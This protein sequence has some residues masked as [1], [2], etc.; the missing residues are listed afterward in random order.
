MDICAYSPERPVSNEEQRGTLAPAPRANWVDGSASLSD[1]RQLRRPAGQNAPTTL[2][3]SCLSADAVVVVADRRLTR[4]DT[5]APLD[6]DACKVILLGGQAAIPHGHPKQIDLWIVD[7]LTPPPSQL[8]EVIDRLGRA[9][10]EAFTPIASRQAARHAFMISGWEVAG[11]RA[12]PFHTQLSNALDAFGRW[13]PAAAPEFA[14][15]TWRLGG[16]AIALKAIGHPLDPQRGRL[17][18]RRLQDVR[19]RHPSRIASLLASAVREEARTTNTVGEGL[20]VTILPRPTGT[21]TRVIRL[22][23][24]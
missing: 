15:R 11:E 22:S 8:Q 10:V 16:D 18:R 24:L 2:V 21:G 9:S 7:V 17:L 14:M 5:G 20:L 4:L 1:A 13:R 23:R 19:N 12:R 3:I 6:D